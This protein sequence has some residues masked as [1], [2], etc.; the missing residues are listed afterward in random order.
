MIKRAIL[1]ILIPCLLLTGCASLLERSY[2]SS[3]PYT[4]RYWDSGVED[5]LK[6]ENYQDLVNS[7]LILIEQHS[8]E[9]V[10]RYYAPEDADPYAHAVGAKHEVQN[11]T[12]LGSYLLESLSLSFTRGDGY[13]TLVYSMTY[14]PDAQDISSLMSLSDTQSLV[15]LLRLAVREGHTSLTA[16]FIAQVSREEIE[17]AV[18]LLWQELYL[19]ELEAS[20][21][22]TPPGPDDSGKTETDETEGSTEGDT[23]V[24]AEDGSENSAEASEEPSDP[25]TPDGTDDT[26]PSDV[27]SE[28]ENSSEDSEHGSDEPD[29]PEEPVIVF[30]PCPWKIIFYPNADHAEIIEIVLKQ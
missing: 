3:E 17:K 5:T 10:I 24:S 14:R 13:C 28:G 21:A 4:D 15:D 18:N 27:P 2:S 20:G 11:D 7:L 1:P 30:P 26:E 8:D 25:T 29:I 19:D 12:I 23:D 22:L 6:A 16:Q 9:V